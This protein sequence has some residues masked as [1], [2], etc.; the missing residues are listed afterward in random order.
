MEIFMKRQHNRTEDHNKVALEI[1]KLC[2]HLYCASLK[3]NKYVVRYVCTA[4]ITDEQIH[5]FSRKPVWRSPYQ[6][7]HNLR[8]FFL[9]FLP[10]TMHGGNTN[11]WGV[12]DKKTNYKYYQVQFTESIAVTDR[13]TQT[14]LH[15]APIDL[16]PECMV[17]CFHIYRL[18]AI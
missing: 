12:S 3:G 14:S 7:L 6:R 11:F 1:N 10:S 13:R 5:R 17:P 18:Y 8:F 4:L 16:L 9:N 2:G 15:E